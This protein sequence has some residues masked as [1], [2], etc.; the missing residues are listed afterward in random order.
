MASDGVSAA[1][2]VDGTGANGTL[3]TRAQVFRTGFSGSGLHFELLSLLVCF[4]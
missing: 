1:A 4:L 3:T 2:G